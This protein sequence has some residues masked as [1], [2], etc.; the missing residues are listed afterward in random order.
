MRLLSEC[1]LHALVPLPKQSQA[2][3][4]DRLMRNDSCCSES[5]A[6]RIKVLRQPTA[7]TLRPASTHTFISCSRLLVTVMSITLK[8]RSFCYDYPRPMVTVDVALF[9]RVGD[10][11]EVLLIKR[12]RS[13]FAGKWALPGGYVDADEPLV[14][15]ARRELRE[16]TGLSRVKLMQVAAYGDP[17][18]DPRGHTVSIAFAGEVRSKKV[19]KAGDDA[20]D[21]NWHSLARLP[22]LAFDHRR[23]IRDAASLISDAQVCLIMRRA[24]G[25]RSRR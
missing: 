11:L 5:V 20:S 15:A 13:P 7:L 24:H 22:S 12:A 3:H 25:L 19:A 14:S 17:G 6:V 2:L 16:E 1:K 8:K 10:H 21:T 23:I 9:R 4:S 18:R